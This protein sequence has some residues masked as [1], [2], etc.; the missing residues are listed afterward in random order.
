MGWG[1]VGIKDD[2]LFTREHTFAICLI[3]S[4]HF[5][6]P[7]GCGRTHYRTYSMFGYNLY[8]NNSNK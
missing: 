2:I 5:E 4:S 1:G 8:L 7:A 3:S 6:Q